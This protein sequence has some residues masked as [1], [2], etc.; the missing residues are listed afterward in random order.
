[1]EQ[2]VSNQDAYSRMLDG[3]AEA[4]RGGSTPYRA[5]GAEGVRNQRVLDAAYRAWRDRDV[6][7][8]E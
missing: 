7:E 6:Q 4:M 8:I 5:L 3:F 1:M 2:P